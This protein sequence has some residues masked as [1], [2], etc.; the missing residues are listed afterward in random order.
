MDQYIQSPDQR[1]RMVMQGDGNL[2]LY[3]GTAAL[4]M[5]GTFNHPGAY[6]AMQSDGNLVIYYQAA[7]AWNSGTGGHPGARL[8]M[9]SD[10]NGVIYT[11]SDQSLW[12]TTTGG[13]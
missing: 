4:W 9:Q 13:R 6:A 11:P 3:Q 8:E 10:G 1:F 5:S 12:Q 7:A 2:V